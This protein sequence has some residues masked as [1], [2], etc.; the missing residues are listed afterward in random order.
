MADSVES[1]AVSSSKAPT[2]GRKRGIPIHKLMNRN[3]C[4]ICDAIPSHIQKDCPVIIGGLPS[5]ERR[6]AELRTNGAGDNDH[7]LKVL[8]GWRSRLKNARRAALK[9]DG[10]AD[11]GSESIT[12]DTEAAPPHSNMDNTDAHS[13]KADVGF[14]VT[15]ANG[16]KRSIEDAAQAE[17]LLSGPVEGSSDG[18]TNSDDGKAGADGEE[19][20]A[21]VNEAPKE[22]GG[23]PHVNGGSATD[24]NDDKRETEPEESETEDQSEDEDD[25]D[26]AP[27][28]GQRS[29]SPPP[30]SQNKTAQRPKV[31]S[32]GTSTPTATLH[33]TTL[34]N[35]RSDIPSLS[36]LRPDILRKPRLSNASS[37]GFVPPA[38]QAAL[39]IGGSRS[40]LG[41]GS[42]GSGS[43][44]ESESESESDSDDEQEGGEA[45]KGKT[46]IPAAL[47]GRMASGKTN[48]NKKKKEE[49]QGW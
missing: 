15:K 9:R 14:A 13:D 20:I 32:N 10:A 33:S 22:M 49:K 37:N 40:P 11:S 18:S 5:I 45:Q 38:S 31:T 42:S 25:E 28:S 34:Y 17:N 46:V 44:S 12:N 1:S 19:A 4:V 23:E 36:S 21:I 16:S 43:G 8:E 47:A 30:A 3:P 2:E 35:P 26:N 41:S 48:G 6:T 29:A 24:D 7:P 39:S 27:P